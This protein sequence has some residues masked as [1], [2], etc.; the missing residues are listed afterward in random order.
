MLK[1]K[2]HKSHPL[3]HKY[4]KNLLWWWWLGCGLQSTLCTVWG[5]SWLLSGCCSAAAEIH[6]GVSWNLLMQSQFSDRKG[7]KSQIFRKSWKGFNSWNYA[8]PGQGVSFPGRDQ[9]TSTFLLEK[10]RAICQVEEQIIN[11]SGTPEADENSLNLIL[12]KYLDNLTR[13]ASCSCSWGA[14]ACV[15]IVG[16]FHQINSRRQKPSPWVPRCWLSSIFKYFAM[17]FS[18][19]LLS[20]QSQEALGSIYQLLSIYF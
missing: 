17:T 1:D 10:S 14:G 2:W 7:P 19:F 11:T 13:D 9:K 16:Q 20:L 8:G 12:K 5:C 18:F 6:R 4:L 15:D 3:L